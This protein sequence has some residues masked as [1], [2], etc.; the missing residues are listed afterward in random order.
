[1]KNEERDIQE[2][3]WVLEREKERWGSERMRIGGMGG[4]RDKREE[5]EEEKIKIKKERDKFTK[6]PLSLTG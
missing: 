1:M 4:G 6:M 5:R 3:C 2:G